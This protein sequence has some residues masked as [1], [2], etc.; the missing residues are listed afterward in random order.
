MRH[1]KLRTVI[2][3][4]TRVT[5]ASLL[6]LASARGLVILA[7]A[8][9]DLAKHHHTITVHEGDA[10]EAF[11]ILE[12]VAHQG[13]L[14]LEAALRHL[15]R[16]ERVWILH[17]LA[18]GLLAHLPLELGDAACRAA[19]THEADWRVA[20]L[21][22]VW[23][24]EDLNLS[25]ELLR[26]PKRGVLLV[27]HHITRPRHV[28]L[29]QAFDV[30]ANVV[31]WI[32]HVHTLVVH[33][34]S[35]DLASAGVRRSVGGQEDNF[36]ARLHNA[37][38]DAASQHITDAL[39]LINSGDGHPHRGTGGPLRHAAH[40]VKHI[41]KCL[42][43]DGLFAH[44]NIHALPPAHV[45]GFLQEVVTHPA[46][47]GQNRGVFLNELFL[48][49]HVNQHALHLIRDFIVTGLLVPG[50]VTIH[51]V[52]T[53]AHLLH[54]QQV[55]QARVLASLA[56]DFARLVVALCGRSREVTVGRHHD[57]GHI[58]LRG[59]RDHVLDEI[60]VSR[61]IDDGIVPL[62]SEAH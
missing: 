13:L 9:D 42:H 34:D 17:F 6:L 62:L 40:L 10:G 39:D 59:A 37:L 8:R 30:E 27:H 32:G 29:V 47:D 43:V 44:F 61:R 52:H 15:V 51:L 16:L 54:A 7:L 11:A 53:N 20:D 26:L 14:R 55:D 57:Q 48:P 25:I 3:E 49:S 22:L 12:G 19:A 23:N 60:T 58:R 4:A 1:F 31:T 46:G 21:D 35:E 5:S 24:I 18:P 33:L 50:C 36:L 28:L 56:L 41:V 38:L 45:A 2:T